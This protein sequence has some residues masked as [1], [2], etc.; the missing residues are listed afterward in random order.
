MTLRA[1]RRSARA[2]RKWVN[3]GVPALAAAHRARGNANDPRANTP[4]PPRAL[5]TCNA[6]TPP[7]LKHAHLAVCGAIR[8]APPR[9]KAGP[10]TTVGQNAI[11]AKGMQA[12]EYS[13]R[14]RK[15]QGI[16]GPTAAGAPFCSCCERK[17]PTVWRTKA[18]PLAR[19]AGSG[20]TLLMDIEVS[21]IRTHF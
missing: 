19:S 20:L 12:N 18:G 16:S 10:S 1:Q 6:R 7:V 21:E 9:P 2:R 8:K 3:R 17:H 11:R 14:M 13:A 4:N 5:R 15:W